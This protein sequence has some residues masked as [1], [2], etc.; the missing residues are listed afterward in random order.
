M[1]C[2]PLRPARGILT[3]LAISIAVYTVIILAWSFL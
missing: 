3:G 1:I 2:D